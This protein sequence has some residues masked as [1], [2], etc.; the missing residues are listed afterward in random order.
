MGGRTGWKD[1]A[2]GLG[3]RTRQKDQVEGPGLLGCQLRLPTPPT[4]IGNHVHA[5]TYTFVLSNFLHVWGQIWISLMDK[6]KFLTPVWIPH[7]RNTNWCD[8]YGF[9]KCRN[10]YL[11]DC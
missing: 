6:S 5:Y 1:W 10:P 3:R 2:E 8:K 11:G 4:P 9:P 7:W